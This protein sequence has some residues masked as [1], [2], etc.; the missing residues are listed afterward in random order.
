MAIVIRFLSWEWLLTRTRLANGSTVIVLRA[1]GTALYFLIGAV[2]LQNILDPDRQHTASLESFSVRTLRLQVLEMGHWFTAVFAG[3]YVALYARFSSQWSYLAGL[4]NQI[5]AA[6]C[7]GI[8]DSDQQIALAEW[9][10]AFIEDAEE[11]HLATKPMVA[12][13]IS[14]W[15]NDSR[16]RDA[17][18]IDVPGGQMRLEALID[19]VRR[20]R[21]REE[22]RWTHQRKAK[23]LRTEPSA[24]P[25][26]A[27]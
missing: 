16:I 10:A 20:V 3:V 8:L 14:V 22:Y 2:L 12:T 19:R 13:I 9:K 1:F 6:E 7:R 5:K 25:V 11:L 18:V 17:F 27:P 4:Y 26:K 21:A 15:V 23:R 24:R